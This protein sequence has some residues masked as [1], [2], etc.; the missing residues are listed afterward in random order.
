[1]SREYTRDNRI[2]NGLIFRVVVQFEIEGIWRIWTHGGMMGSMEYPKIGLEVVVD[3]H[4]GL[5]V[6]V[7]IDES[8]CVA[9]LKLTTG[10]HFI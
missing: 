3:G 7:S 1:M 4:E 10:T 8:Q 5:F 2:G 6:I 9:V